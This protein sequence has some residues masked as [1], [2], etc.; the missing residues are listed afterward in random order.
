[1]PVLAALPDSA[2]DMKS[3][4][5]R[6]VSGV[7]FFFAVALLSGCAELQASSAA[8]GKTYEQLVELKR[9]VKYVNYNGG[10]LLNYDNPRD[11]F[12]CYRCDGMPTRTYTNKAGNKVAVY[13]YSRAVDYDGWCSSSGYSMGCSEPVSICRMAEEHYEFRDGVVSD[14]KIV[15]GQG[16]RPF[17]GS[18]VCAHFNPRIGDRDP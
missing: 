13:F 5:I 4:S 9:S 7:L 16:K 14:M 8:K 1:M 6:F 15:T 2:C 3:Q 10:G 12:D 18:N 11:R 17:D